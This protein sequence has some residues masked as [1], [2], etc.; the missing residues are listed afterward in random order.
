MNMFRIT[1]L[2]ALALLCAGSFAAS[3][4]SVGVSVQVGDGQPLQDEVIN[5]GDQPATHPFCVR[6]TGSRIAPRTR[7]L[8]ASADGRR[9]RPDCVPTAGRVYTR[10]DLDSTGAVD[11]GDALRRLDPSIR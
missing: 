6:S 10:H 11:I 9:M 3:A 5:P 7:P 4:Q 2:G 8:A 1:R